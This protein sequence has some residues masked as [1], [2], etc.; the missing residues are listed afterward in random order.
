MNIK[1]S[2][3]AVMSIKAC[4]NNIVRVNTAMNDDDDDN[5]DNG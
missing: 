2:V 4:K 5:D 1:V 3:D